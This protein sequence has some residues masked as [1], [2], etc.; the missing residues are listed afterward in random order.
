MSI[1]TDHRQR[2]KN[3]FLKEGLENFDDLHILELMLFYCVPRRDT[4]VLAHNLLNRFGTLPKV[5]D[6]TPEQLKQV[7]GIGEGAATFVKFL[8]EFARVC[9]IRRNQDVQIINSHADIQRCLLSVLNHQR[10]ETVYILCMDAKRK[11]L[12]IEKVGEGSVNSANVPVRRI[13]EIALA[14]NA[15][16]VILAHNHPGGLAIPSPDDVTATQYVARALRAVEVELADH[17][18]VADGDC[19]SLLLSGAY[20]PGYD[21]L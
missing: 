16:S 20:H 12:C 4:N 13:V 6:A 2:V 5:M 17:V 21:N 10:N 1:H 8:R 3:R 11:V 19:I 15:T 7:D 14:Y 18:V 9:E